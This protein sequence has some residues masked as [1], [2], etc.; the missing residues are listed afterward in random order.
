ML[1]NFKSLFRRDEEAIV[2]AWV[3]EMYAERRTELTDLLAYGQLVDPLPDLLEEL[4]GILDG[5]ASH[6]EIEE[7]AH[8]LRSHAQVRFRL[9][10]LIDEVAR[11]LMIFRKVVN[12]FLWRECI[13]VTQGDLWELRDALARSDRFVD[14]LIAQVIVVYAASHRPIVQTRESAW[15]PPRL[16]RRSDFP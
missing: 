9:G 11:E 15:P 3:D 12:E 7:A 2:R 16:R 1:Q 8:R 10:A 5:A 4:V 6:L 14:E 13:C